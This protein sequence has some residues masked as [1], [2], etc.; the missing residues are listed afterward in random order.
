ML[1]GYAGRGAVHS[2][3]RWLYTAIAPPSSAFSVAARRSLQL[4]TAPVNVA[5]PCLTQPRLV[6]SSYR[7]RQSNR[8]VPSATSVLL[9][10]ACV[11]GF[12]N[13]ALQRRCRDAARSIEL[14]PSRLHDAGRA[15]T[16]AG[17]RWRIHAR[18]SGPLETPRSSCA[19][20]AREDRP[21]GA[22][23]S[24]QRGNWPQS[25]WSRQICGPATRSHRTAA[26]G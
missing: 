26:K 20:D 16:C 17:T 5:L 13:S 9:S 18:H 8:T 24:W 15:V 1:S 3:R 7:P 25:C 22:S 23:P 12:E 2:T 14:V 21:A 19:G 4:S 10:Y 6:R 11:I